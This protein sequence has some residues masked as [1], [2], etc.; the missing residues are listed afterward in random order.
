MGKLSL[1]KRIICHEKLKK[2][3]DIGV[4]IIALFTIFLGYATLPHKPLLFYISYNAIV[5]LV[6]IF[7]LNQYLR[8]R[9]IKP[10]GIEIILLSFQGFMTIAFQVA[11][12]FIILTKRYDLYYS[13]WV[14]IAFVVGTFLFLE[15]INYLRKQEGLEPIG[16]QDNGARALRIINL[17]IITFIVFHQTYRPLKIIEFK[18]LI[19]PTVVEVSRYDENQTNRIRIELRDE[20]LINA[21]FQELDYLKL[22]NVRN[23]NRFNY[24]RLDLL[25]DHYHLLIPLYNKEG[26]EPSAEFVLDEHKVTYMRLYP[27]RALIFY[28]ILDHREMYWV[29]LSEELYEQIQ[30]FYTD[31][32][33]Q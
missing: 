17:I 18:E 29:N 13:Y 28:S 2:I 21:L 1:I 11:S 4:C 16:K 10:K 23:F 31:A 33:L 26:N 14:V 6:V 19:R 20:A 8:D 32:S 7:F 24:M 15:A 27:N 22:R 12:Y 9:P 5:I 30:G 25:E 3:V